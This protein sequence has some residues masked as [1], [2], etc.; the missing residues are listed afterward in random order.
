MISLQNAVMIC[1]SLLRHICFFLIG[2]HKQCWVRAC[3]F[4]FGRNQKK[5]L[6]AEYAWQVHN[7]HFNVFLNLLPV[8]LKNTT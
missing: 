1:S 5:C 6:S 8:I 3:V 7:I 4:M 2:K